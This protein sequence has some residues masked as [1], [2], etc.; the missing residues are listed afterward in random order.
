MEIK[1]TENI[2]I[3]SDFLNK[4]QVFLTVKR[5]DL[6]HKYI[7]GNK[8]R[9][10]KYNIIEAKKQHKQTLLSFGGAYSNHIEA[11][12]F[13]GH[14]LGMNTIGLIRGDELSGQPLNPTLTRAFRNGM[15]LVFITRKQYSRK[16]EKVF[17]MELK[18]D[19]GDFYLIPEGGTNH[20]AVLGCEEIIGHQEHEFDVIASSV[21]TGGTISGIINA[22]SCSQK[23]IGFSALKGD[24]LKDYIVDKVN[25]DNWELNEEYHFGG[26]AKV[27][28]ELIDF[29][30]NFKM[31][32]GIPLDPIYT[33]KMMF[34]IYD[35]IKKGKF[36]KNTSIL[37]IHTGG[38]Q[39]IDGMNQVLQKKG[40]KL[41]V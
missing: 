26:Y 31:E 20:L 1:N 37:A 5:E 13:A 8:F 25:K 18:N 40:M 30:N 19:F 10:L 4:N 29:I 28:N 16:E 36:Q 11:L 41:I 3:E 23:V 21:G 22:S 15:K 9:K 34:G 35:L 27:T 39:G 12:S 7:S 24:F 33:G 32:T 6:I 2:K 14:E 38:L 17:L